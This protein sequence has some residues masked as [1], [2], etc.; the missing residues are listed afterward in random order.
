MR[1]NKQTRV[2]IEKADA[3][4]V[5]ASKMVSNIVNVFP[6]ELLKKEIAIT[7]HSQG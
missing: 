3:P 6:H 1:M 5:G 7:I 2:T 4:N